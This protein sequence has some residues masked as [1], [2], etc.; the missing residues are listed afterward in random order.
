MALDGINIAGLDIKTYDTRVAGGGNSEKAPHYI[1][2]TTQASNPEDVHKCG[3]RWSSSILLDVV[4]TYPAGGNTGSRV[5]ADDIAEEVMNRVNG[6]LMEPTSGL[7]ILTRHVYL[8]NDIA[9]STSEIIVQRKLVRCVFHLV[10][11]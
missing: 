2:M 9:F 11:N 5:I 10:E 4:T 7:K 6:L 8:E 1:L 3:Y